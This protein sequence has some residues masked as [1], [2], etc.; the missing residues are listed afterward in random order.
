MNKDT[1]DK[2]QLPEHG[3]LFESPICGIAVKADG[4]KIFVVSSGGRN[5]LTRVID[6]N[7]PIFWE[8]G[9]DFPYPKLRNPAL[10]HMG[11]TFLAAGGQYK[12]GSNFFYSDEIYR[13]EPET[14]DWTLE[15]QT[16]EKQMY[17]GMGVLVDHQ[18]LGYS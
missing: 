1:G 12:V 2:V 14:Y 9:V 5:Q 18:S 8:A 6:V 3:E 10:V 13:F 17:H 4:T 7:N 16:L 11:H 15:A